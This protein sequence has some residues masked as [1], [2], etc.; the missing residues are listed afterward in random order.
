MSLE[1]YI[2]RRMAK[3]KL[4][5]R[6]EDIESEL[7]DKAPPSVYKYRNWADPNHRSILVNCE[8]WFSHPFDLNDSEDIRPKMVFDKSEFDYPEYFEKM[9][10]SAG[11]NT[12]RENRVRAENKLEEMKADPNLLVSNAENYYRERSNF[13]KI[14]IFSTAMGELNEHVWKEYSSDHSGFCLG[15]NTIE[16][17]RQ[18]KSGY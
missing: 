3:P 18:M 1:L 17:C 10:A 6:F 15:F 11:M 13:D 7:A 16:L 2:Q 5:T 9:V 14:G 8:A 4:F 12:E